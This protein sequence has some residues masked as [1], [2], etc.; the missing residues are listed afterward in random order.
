MSKPD[1]TSVSYKA[2]FREREKENSQLQLKRHSSNRHQLSAWKV[3]YYI[4]HSW[5]YKKTVSWKHMLSR[6]FI[7]SQVSKQN[8]REFLPRQ[9]LFLLFDPFPLPSP[10]SPPAAGLC[11]AGRTCFPSPPYTTRFAVSFYLP[12]LSQ[13]AWRF[14][15]LAACCGGTKASSMAR[16]KFTWKMCTLTGSAMSS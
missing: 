6:G 9:H 16:P 5:A 3:R 10:K 4:C 2:T 14:L 11:T 15:I 12:H 13:P 7:K 8:E 1:I